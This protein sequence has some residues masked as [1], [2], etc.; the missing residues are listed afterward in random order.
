M[1]SVHNDPIHH[2]IYCFV[3]TCPAASKKSS[4]IIFEMKKKN[5]ARI[6]F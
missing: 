2:N 4:S 5:Q 6:D 3:D 1:S